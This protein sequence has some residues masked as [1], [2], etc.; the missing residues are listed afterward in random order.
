MRPHADIALLIVG[1]LLTTGPSARA[2]AAA[3]VTIVTLGDSITKGVR[4]GVKAEETFSGLLQE[5]LRASGSDAT[6]INTGIGGEDT[7]QALQRFERTVLARKPHLVTI[8]YGANDH[9]IHNGKTGPKVPPERF[10]ANL[11]TMIEGVRKAGGRPILMTTQPAVGTAYPS[12]YDDAPARLDDYVKITR[13][14]AKEL[15]VPLVD[16]HAHWSRQPPATLQKWV[17]DPWHP[18]PAGHRAMAD[19]L[20]P[21]VRDALKEPNPSPK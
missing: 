3:P 15:K 1:L 4:P 20:V 19:L 6:V 18:N 12:G 21:V 14:V 13:A 2:G 8:M 9:W 7:D 5:R 11:R 16:H 10:A 17:T